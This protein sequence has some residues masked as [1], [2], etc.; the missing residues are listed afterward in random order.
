MDTKLAHLLSQEWLITNG[1]GGFASGTVAGAA[2]RRYHSLLTAALNPPSGRMAMLAGV[3]ETL[4]FPDGQSYSL[5]T[6]LY[7]DG[8]VFPNGWEYITDFQY[9]RNG[10]QWVFTLPNGVEITKKLSLGYENTTLHWEV[11]KNPIKSSAESATI[12]IAPLV[13]WKD[14]HAEMKVWDGFP[15]ESKFLENYWFFQATPDAAQLHL[16]NFGNFGGTWD[17]GGWW[18]KNIFHS[19]ERDRG[20]DSTEDI[21]CPAVL[22]VQANSAQLVVRVV[23]YSPSTKHYDAI[24][25]KEKPFI[26]SANQF[27]VQGKDRQSVIAGYPWFC[28][29]GRDTFI[30]LPGLCLATKQHDIAREILLSFTKWVQNGRIPNKFP[31]RDEAPMYNN[32][33]GTLWYLRACRLYENVTKDAA[34][35]QEIAPVREAILTAHRNNTVGEEIYVAENGL[36]HA[37]NDH[38]NLTWMD[39]KVDGI[40][41]TPRHGFPVEVNA[42]WLEATDFA[43]LDAFLEAFVRPDSLGLYDYLPSPNQSPPIIGGG[44]GDQI[45]PNMVIAAAILGDKIPMEIRQEVLQVA[46]EHLLTPYGLRTLSPTDPAYAGRYEGGPKERDAV[47]HQGTVWPWLIGPFLTLYK[48]VHGADSDISG[49]IAPLLEHFENDYGIGGI[50]EI[51]DGDAPHRPNGCPWQ[52]WSLAALLEHIA[53]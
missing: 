46:T 4:I 9:F 5:A 7:E 13:Y 50:A 36:L 38:T 14:M 8:T 44:G 53:I 6:H 15:T 31:D 47:Y 26:A 39:A 27:L 49:F 16:C 11:T 12:Q 37:G 2:T 43:A 21:Y 35:S 24:T 29:W 42:L 52:A 41:I 48:S 1:T 32:V 19:I 25:V 51:F 34:F 23:P 20:F 17:I 3:D 28:D 18:N 30:S 10:V 33:D 22:T 40:P 45:R